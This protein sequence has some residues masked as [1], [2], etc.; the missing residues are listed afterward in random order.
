MEDCKLVPE[1]N[2]GGGIAQSILTIQMAWLESCCCQ[3]NY[4]VSRVLSKK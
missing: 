4:L 1:I 2:Q 3:L